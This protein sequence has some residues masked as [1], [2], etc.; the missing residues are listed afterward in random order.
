MATGCVAQVLSDKKPDRPA[1]ASGPGLC[2][3]VVGGLGY[4]ELRAA[5]EV[6]KV[7]EYERNRGRHRD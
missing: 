3:F 1:E 4:S 7:R 5:Y 6:A 2:V